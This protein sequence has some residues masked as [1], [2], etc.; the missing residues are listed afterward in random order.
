MRSVG[1]PHGEG[2]SLSSGVV[3]RRRSA[4]GGSCVEREPPRGD[5]APPSDSA[6]RQPGSPA[7]RRRRSRVFRDAVSARRRSRA[8]VQSVE[9][10]I[11][12]QT[13][14]ETRDHRC[15]RRHR[16]SSSPS[17]SRQ[18]NR[19]SDPRPDEA[20]ANQA[21]NHVQRVFLRASRAARSAATRTSHVSRVDDP[22]V[23]TRSQR[24]DDLAGLLARYQYLKVRVCPVRPRHVRAGGAHERAV[25]R[26]VHV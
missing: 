14:P 11:S 10:L 20:M 25:L 4:R 6:R 17:S 3:G 12:R 1:R 21:S 9:D 24:E 5:R 18:Q 16:T 7:P 26:H 19:E 15:G 23:R 8:A 22:T 2:P 13:P